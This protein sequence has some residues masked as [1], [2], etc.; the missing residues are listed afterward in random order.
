MKYIYSLCCDVIV[1]FGLLWYLYSPSDATYWVHILTMSIIGFI[2]INV[3]FLLGMYYGKYKP[4][5][6]P[7]M[8]PAWF[9][10]LTDLAIVYALCRTGHIYMS[11]VYYTGSIVLNLCMKRVR[12]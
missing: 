11:V 4:V 7:L 2:S 6:V 12:K 8:L 9:N 5:P 3:L 10:L 1:V